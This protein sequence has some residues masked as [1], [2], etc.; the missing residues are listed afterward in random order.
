MKHAT[1]LWVSNE[2]EEALTLAE[3]GYQE[4]NIDLK[5][6]G[7][8]KA[9]TSKQKMSVETISDFIMATNFGLF[10]HLYITTISYYG[11]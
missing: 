5:V 1:I 3:Q 9:F 6:Q 7:Y 11:F 8:L 10:M 2:T 4:A